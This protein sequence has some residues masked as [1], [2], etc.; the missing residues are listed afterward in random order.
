[1]GVDGVELLCGVAPSESVLIVEMSF[2][3]S[4]VAAISA[5]G[6]SGG[7]GCGSI[8][9]IVVGEGK[10]GCTIDSIGRGHRCV[11]RSMFVGG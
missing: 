4:T 3:G 11:G 9:G 7:S 1:M 6:C 2:S 8:V 5:L 10:V